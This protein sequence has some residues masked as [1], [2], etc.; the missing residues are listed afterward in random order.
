[1]ASAIRAE[2]KLLRTN[3]LSPTRWLTI[4]Q[5]PILPLAPHFSIILVT[6][7][8]SSARP[9]TTT[10]NSTTRTAIIP[11]RYSRSPEISHCLYRISLRSIH[12][13]EKLYRGAAE[14]I[15]RGLFESQRGWSSR[16]GNRKAFG[17]RIFH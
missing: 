7:S 1:T 5:P 13:Q 2:S 8:I 12:L 11:L 14:E 17:G 9:N 3:F 4:L 16:S 10:I 6:S 15:R